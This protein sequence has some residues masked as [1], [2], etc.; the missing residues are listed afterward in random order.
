MEQN[1]QVLLVKQHRFAVD[2]F[3]WEIPA[4]KLEYGEDPVSCGLRELNEETGYT[5]EKLEMLHSFYSTPGFCDERLWVYQA[6][7][8]SKAEHKLPPDPDEDITIQ[9]FTLHELKQMLQKK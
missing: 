6:I 3:T 9:W 2:Q 5:C 7:H 4:G 1:D 8:P